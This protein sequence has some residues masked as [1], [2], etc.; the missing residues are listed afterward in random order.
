MAEH[1]DWLEGF[2][3]GLKGPL[4]PQHMFLATEFNKGSLDWATELRDFIEALTGDSVSDW[5]RFRG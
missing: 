5:S 3:E 2:A 1:P 4:D